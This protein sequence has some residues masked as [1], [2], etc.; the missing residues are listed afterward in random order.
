MVRRGKRG[1]CPG[2]GLGTDPRSWRSILRIGGPS[3]LARLPAGLRGITPCAASCGYGGNESALGPSPIRLL[4]V[5]VGSFVRLIETGVVNKPYVTGVRGWGFCRGCLWGRLPGERAAGTHSR[6]AVGVLGR[7]G[8][9]RASQS[10]RGKAPT[11]WHHQAL[12][13]QH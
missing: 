7:V 1:V 11:P 4:P 8:H 9:P 6:Q 12:R 10:T 2:R 3:V 5:W 13:Q